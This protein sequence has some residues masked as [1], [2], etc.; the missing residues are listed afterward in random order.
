L[1]GGDRI[2]RALTAAL[3]GFGERLAE[4]QTL[5]D[6]VNSWVNRVVSHMVVPNRQRLGAFIAGVVR[7]WNPRT[8]VGK[9]ELQVGR[10]LQYIR[11]NGTVVGGLVG[12]AIHAV[13]VTM[14]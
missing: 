9:L 14:G 5:R 2:E 1:A 7:G 3:L 6:V 4:D 12:L 13:A 10:D 11:I 8:L